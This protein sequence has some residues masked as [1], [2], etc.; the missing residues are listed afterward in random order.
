MQCCELLRHQYTEDDFI[1]HILW[2]K[3]MCF[4][5][6]SVLN[7]CDGPSGRLSSLRKRGYQVRFSVTIGL[8]SSR[9]MRW[10]PFTY[11]AGWVIKN[12]IIFLETDLPWLLKDVGLSDR[13]C[14]SSTTEL[15]LITK[16][17]SVGSWTRPVQ[18]V[19]SRL[20]GLLRRRI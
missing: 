1:F 5:Y 7:L 4:T 2:T 12:I 13:S 6:E 19:E 15:Q 3:D 17:T 18:D 14:G 8:V 9:T 20:C 11:L 10:T 16:N